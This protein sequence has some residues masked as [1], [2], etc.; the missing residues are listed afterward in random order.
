MPAPAALTRADAVAL[1]RA[2]P[3]AS[4]RSRFVGLGASAY[5]MGNSLGPLPA[6]TEVRLAR[7]VRD[8]WGTER[9][10]GW[11]RWLDLPTRVGD[12]LGALLGAERGQV[13]LGDSTSV[14]LY[15][16]LTDRYVVAGV[17]AARGRTVRTVATDG[18]DGPVTPAVVDAVCA[19]RAVAVVAA[20][21]VRFRTGARAD[22]AAVTAA[23]HRHGALVLWDLSHAA[24]SVSVALDAAE[25]DLAVGCTT[26]T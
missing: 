8:E 12:R 23:A 6:A 18:P 21:L 13:V 5:L 17:A 26:S 4:M 3:L 22:L 19:G 1:D 24:G 15:K 20:S 25:V 2:N 10:G 11:S 9:V 14:Q 16:L 7:F